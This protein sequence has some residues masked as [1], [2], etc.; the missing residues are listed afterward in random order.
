MSEY[1]NLA[2]PFFSQRE[3]TYTWYLTDKNSGLH[4]G[5]GI[6]M[7][8][9]SCNITSLCMILQYL[10]ITDD[11]PDDV[12]KKIYEI[13]FKSW[14]YNTDYRTYIEVAEHLKDVL[15]KTY[16]INDDKIQLY[17]SWSTKL[18]YSDIKKYL[19]QGFPIWFSWGIISGK[20]SGHI[21]VI[22]GITETGAISVND[23]WGDPTDA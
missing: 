10:G 3:N 15:K 5:T 16:S 17:S 14:S 23:P 21:S 4:I 22:R 12:M 9:Q 1:I 18:R 2:V 20:T 7:A 19:K 13:D 8:C 6:S 11:S